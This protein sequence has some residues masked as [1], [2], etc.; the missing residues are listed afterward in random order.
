MWGAEL[1]LDRDKM[2]RRAPRGAGTRA[3]G[4]AATFDKP[5]DVDDLRAVLLN[6]TPRRARHGG[7]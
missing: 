5:F 1:C 7:C 4:A 6:L 2:G 3:I